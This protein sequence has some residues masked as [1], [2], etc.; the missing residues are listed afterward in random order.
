MET[1]PEILNLNTLHLTN[2]PNIYKKCSKK[3]KHNITEITMTKLP[4]ERLELAS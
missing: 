4:I 3:S 1:F 2:K